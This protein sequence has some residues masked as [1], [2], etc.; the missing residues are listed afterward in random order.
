MKAKKI[1]L[2]FVMMLTALSANAQY[3]PG[4]W[5]IQIKFGYGASFL[6]NLDKL[7]MSTSSADSEP[8]GSSTI[9]MD[10]EY[11]VSKLLGV[12]FGLGRIGGGGGW[13]DYTEN[14]VKYKDSQIKL[15]YLCFP[16][17]A[18]FYIYKGLA[19]KTGVQVGYL[20]GA[21]FS[22]HHVTNYQNRDLTTK[23]TLDL[24]DDCKKLDIAIP[25]GVSYETKGHFV[26]DLR[27]N[28]GVTKINDGTFLG[29]KD[30]KNNNVMLTFGYKFDL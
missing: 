24:E 9:G 25:I 21:D 17:T 26:W 5:A 3:D 10:V 6:S 19:L 28:Y 11:Q 30:L 7:P 29:T 14:S 1:V 27:F 16:F 12:S 23:H 20:I 22:Q 8:I 4:K 15:E 13:E 2:M 18:N